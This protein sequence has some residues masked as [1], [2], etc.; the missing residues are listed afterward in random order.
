MESGLKSLLTLVLLVICYAGGG[1]VSCAQELNCTVNLNYD[2][3]FAQQKTDVQTMDQLKIYI[4]DFMN[5]NRWTNDQFA[6]KSA[7]SVS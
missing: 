6:R 4:S 5:T 1:Q 7:S 2:Q 3:L